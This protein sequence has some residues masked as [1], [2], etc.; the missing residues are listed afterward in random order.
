M[1]EEGSEHIDLKG[2]HLPAVKVG[3][4]RISQNL[5]PNIDKE[6]KEKED[7]ENKIAQKDK[8]INLSGYLSKGNLDFTTEAVKAFHDKPP[9]ASKDAPRSTNYFHNEKSFPIQQPRK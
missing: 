9:F 1:T 6:E 2:G 4:M 3:G 8:N 7:T 5:P